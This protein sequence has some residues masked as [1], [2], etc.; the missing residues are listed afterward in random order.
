MYAKSSRPERFGSST[1]AAGC[2]PSW[3]GGKGRRHA[4]GFGCVVGCFSLRLGAR[5]LSLAGPGGLAG[6]WS[7]SE[8]LHDHLVYY[9]RWSVPPGSW[10]RSALT[11]LTLIWAAWLL[12]WTIVSIRNS[13]RLAPGREL[14][15][16][17]TVPSPLFPWARGRWPGAF[18]SS[19]SQAAPNGWPRT[20]ATCLGW[21]R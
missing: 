16:L 1:S 10:A 8:H 2:G 20:C 17:E 11:M 5:V 13:G 6:R 4:D 18:G 15:P 19:K 12:G 9:P 14:F 3:T 21:T 7:R